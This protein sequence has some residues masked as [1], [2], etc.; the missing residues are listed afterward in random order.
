MIDLDDVQSNHIRRCIRC[1]RVITP[2]IDSGWQEF[3]PDGRTTQP[4]CTI[5][6]MYNLE[7]PKATT[8]LSP[9]APP[10]DPAV[11]APRQ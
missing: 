9:D 3:L 7:L 11:S 8:T 4:V 5:C 10:S 1:G 2:D 6:N